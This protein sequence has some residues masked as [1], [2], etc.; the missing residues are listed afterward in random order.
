[1]KNTTKNVNFTWSLV[2]RGICPLGNPVATAATG[3]SSALYLDHWDVQFKTKT[4]LQ[5]GKKYLKTYFHDI[6]FWVPQ[7]TPQPCLDKHTQLHMWFQRLPFPLP[8]QWYQKR[9][10]YGH[11]DKSNQKWKIFTRRRSFLTGLAALRQSLEVFA[12]VSSP[13]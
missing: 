6:T 7:H 12:V 11:N 3:M 8:F 9:E 4:Q 1:M 13:D 2:G 10:S 5:G